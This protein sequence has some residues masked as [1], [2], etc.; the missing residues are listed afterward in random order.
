MKLLKVALAASFGLVLAGTA[1]S[2]TIVGD[3]NISFNNN[4]NGCGDAATGGFLEN[5]VLLG[6]PFTHNRFVDPQLIN[7][8]SLTAPDFRPSAGGNSV[9]D[10]HPVIAVPTDGFFDQVKFAGALSPIAAENWAVGNW[11]SY[12][13]NGN[14]AEFN[15]GKPLVALTAG[16]LPA[17]YVFMNTNNYL[18]EGRV[19]V[20]TGR[21]ATIQPGTAIFGSTTVTPSY[22]VVERGAKL[23]ANGSPSQPIVFTSE[24][25][26]GGTAG[27]GNWGGVVWHGR[28]CANCA[29]TAAGDS[30]VSEGNAGSFG[31]TDD[32]YDGGTMT[33]TR[34]EFAGFQVAP[35]N[36]LN[37]LTM[38]ALGDRTLINFVQ[39]HQGSDDLF[40]WFGGT[41][42]HKYLIA[43][44]GDD[45]GLDFQMGYRGKVQ[46]AIVQQEANPAVNTVDKGIEG[47]NNEFNFANSLCRSN[48]TFAN[49]TLVGVRT[50]DGPATT[51]N[52][53]QGIHFRRGARGQV[54][55]SIILGF[56][57]CGFDF[58]DAETVAGGFGP[59]GDP[60]C[61]KEVKDPVITWD[62]NVT[63]NNNP[64]GCSDA[65][66]GGF[67]ENTVLFG[68]PFTHNRAVNPILTNPA[69]LSNPNF[70]PQ[71]ASGALCANFHPVVVVKDDGFMTQTNYAGALSQDPAQDWTQGWTTYDP[72][73]NP[74]DFDLSKPLVTLTAGNL[75]DGYVMNNTNNYIIEGRVSVAGGRTLMIQ[76]GT[77]I[78]GS[79]TVT[80]SYLVIERSGQV[81]ANGTRQA[82]IIFTSELAPAGSAAPGNWGGF[83]WH[84]RACANCANTAAG[85]SCV[86]EGNAGSFGGVDDEYNG[87]SLGWAR[88]EFAGFQVAPNNELN[89]LTMNALG[90]GTSI[91]Y[92]QTH[93]GSDDLF[94][95]FGGTVRSKYLLATHGDDDGL[96]FQMG[97]RG[98][99]Q[100]AIVQQEA[101]P[102]ANTVDKG[103]EGDNNEFNFANSLCRSNPQFYNLTLVGVRTTD[104]NSTT[105]NGGQGIHFRR[106]AR[107]EVCNSIVLGFK[108]CGFDFDDAETVAGGFGGN[109]TVFC[110]VTSGVI[111]DAGNGAKGLL[112]R[113]Y[114]NPVRSSSRISF[115]LPVAARAT[116]KI[117]SLSGQLVSTLAEGNLEAGL[118]EMDW[119]PS[120][121]SEGIYFYAV[122]A[123]DRKATGKLVYIR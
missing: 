46:F 27:P 28:A 99:V 26:P 77:A 29:N 13:P 79:T 34:I 50:T 3:G 7:P 65:A 82:P 84:G 8:S 119:T 1:A 12:D 90:Q 64:N 14:P 118:H 116:V 108:T 31:G 70:V 63:F 20:A 94:E 39:T 78:F 75:P 86:S 102:A 103:I 74:A 123:G 45:D 107:G 51:S 67:L 56:K 105:S 38:N 40:E 6:S 42:R 112:A 110:S 37:C 89:C 16:N 54:L 53:G 106:G 35:N 100:F 22:F 72:N 36:E 25:A 18:I 92:I 104:G 81:L 113:A 97:Y 43:T 23:V 62:G 88:V 17:N 4:P 93:Q 21:K 117:F 32:T 83:V 57:T 59:D 9:C 96:D 47:D 95:W 24:L 115:T 80:P 44:H 19:S 76:A 11:V 55:N 73:G 10:T 52:G 58:D 2:Q 15:L 87:G 122:D 30:C 101:N 114:P 61:P 71:P 85:D 109:G 33:Y 111:A 60:V 68:S 66:T 5:N 41:T 98:K 69:S 121:L 48:P 91:N 49:L 120:D